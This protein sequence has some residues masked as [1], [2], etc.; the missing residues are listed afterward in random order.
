VAALLAAGGF[1]AVLI[2]SGALLVKIQRRLVSSKAELPSPEGERLSRLW[3][4]GRLIFGRS[5]RWQRWSELPWRPAREQG[6][7]QRREPD[8]A[9]GARQIQRCRSCS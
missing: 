7:K 2:G 1:L 3:L 4:R 6:Q 5:S 8:V 9:R